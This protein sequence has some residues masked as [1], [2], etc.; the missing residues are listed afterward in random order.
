[1]T[2]KKSFLT[3][4]KNTLKIPDNAGILLAISGGVDSMCMLRLFENTRYRLMVAHVNFQLR[5]EDS[6]GDELLIKNYCQDRE[7]GFQ[8][9]R[10][11][12][13]LYARENKISTQMAAREFRYPWFN[14]LLENFHL[15][16][17]ATAH[18]AE[19]SLETALLNLTRGTG[20][21]GLKGILPKQGKLIR[22]LLFAQKSD[23]MAFAEIEKIEWREDSSNASDKYKRNFIRHQVVPLL[24]E[25]NPKLA[26]NFLQTSKRIAD[27]LEFIERLAQEF[28]TKNVN[29]SS[30]VNSI[31]KELFFNADNRV[32]VEFWLENFNFNY[33]SIDAILNSK[34]SLSGS[35]FL[36]ETHKLIIDREAVFV[37]TNKDKTEVKLLIDEHTSGLNGD[38]GHL[39]F[40]LI[41]EF[42]TKV[43]LTNSSLAFLDLTKLKFPLVLRNWA[44]GDKFNP[45][46]MKGS[47]LIS[48]FLIDLKIT[49]LE[50]E[51]VLVLCS[52]EDIVWVL[53]HRTSA[54]AAIESNTSNV[55]KIRYS[56]C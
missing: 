30:N 44:L 46:G 41:S 52:D 26:F 6:T 27:N 37:F 18:H 50:K 10:F 40:E 24:K 39:T 28:I 54:I 55:L 19:D 36:S 32:L 48:D 11:D 49:L 34:E 33:T 23:I 1:M 47:K 22:P 13:L 5:G 43:E 53:G 7:I 31:Q 45:Y 14:Q 25:Q 9:I 38:F 8:S 51:K 21:S 35:Q 3:Y 2:L 29:I 20:L 12:T 17:I 56:A 16:Y 4:L 42:P 15:D